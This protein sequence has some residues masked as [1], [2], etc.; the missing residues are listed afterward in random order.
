MHAHAN[1]PYNFV[2]SHTQRPTERLPAKATSEHRHEHVV[3]VRRCRCDHYHGRYHLRNDEPCGWA[4]RTAARSTRRT[5]HGPAHGHVV[6]LPCRVRHHHHIIPHCT[7]TSRHS[8]IVVVATSQSTRHT[9]IT[10]TKDAASFH[11][12]PHHSRRAQQTP[13]Y[14]TSQHYTFC[15]ELYTHSN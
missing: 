14:Q 6:V 13:P 4:A 11:P 5:L 2:R 9:I 8:K 15:Y 7:H 1:S 10:I 3:C 12:V